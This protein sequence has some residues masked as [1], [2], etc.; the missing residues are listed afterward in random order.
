MEELMINKINKPKKFASQ[1]ISDMKN[2]RGITFKYIDEELAVEYLASINNYL[3]TAAYRKNYQK[4]QTGSKKGKYLN[5]DFSY[6]IEL[7]VLDMHYRFLVQK[8]CSDIEHSMCVKLIHDIEKDAT[9]D[10]YD[11]VK[12]FLNRYPREVQKIQGTIALPHTRNL[13]R[14]YFTIQT[15]SNG[16]HR[17]TNYDDC[18]VWVLMELLSFGSIINFYLDYYD[19]RRQA[20]IPKEVLNLVR[21][22]RNAAAHNNCIL[23]DLN[24]GTTVAPQ[25]IIDYV[26]NIEGITKSS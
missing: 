22:L 14:K 8:M 19:S 10:G 26:K 2:D 1:L 3:R 20:H 11:L 7:S 24:S 12:T 13:L 5:L 18:P 9:T 4:Y 6:L 16:Y 15:T 17:I 23:S 25:A 21:S